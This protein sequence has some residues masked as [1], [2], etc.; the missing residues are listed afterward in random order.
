M[1][2][3]SKTA[4]VLRMEGKSHRT[5]QELAFREKQEQ[6]L[7]SGMR[8]QEPAS[9][10][11]DKEAHR[12]FLKT[13]RLL[14]SIGKDDEMYS[15]AVCRYCTNTSK[16]KDC[17][18]SIEMAKAAL[19]ELKE[20]RSKFDDVGEFA[21][22]YRLLVKLEDAVT[23]KEQLGAALRRELCDFEKEFCMT[24]AS[25]GKIV[26]KQPPTKKSVLME[27]LSGP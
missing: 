6:S 4:E 12:V 2:R 9:I 18:T 11:K 8:L 13:R 1:A 7:L 15:A 17:E 21:E 22:Y 24:V 3:P 26:Q 27:A 10:K 19:E 16:L 25:S 23:K 14:S 20:S 5:K